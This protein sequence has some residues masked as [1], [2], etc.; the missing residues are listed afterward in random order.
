MARLAFFTEL[1][2]QAGSADDVTEFSYAV[3][4]SL[5]DQQHDVRVFS[6][7]RESDGLPPSHPRLQILRPFRRW[8]WLEIPRLL[9]ILLEFQPEI[10][11]FIQPRREAF[12]GFTNATT[13][14]PALAP[15]IGRPRVVVSLY[16]VRARELKRNRLLLAAADTV[17]VANKQQAD[18]LARHLADKPYAPSIEIVGLPATASVDEIEVL[19]GLEQLRTETILFIP[20][21]VDEHKDLAPLLNDLMRAIPSL[22]VIIGGGYGSMKSLERREFMSRLDGSRVLLTGPLTAAGE[23]ACLEASSLVLLAGLAP[24]SLSLARY[25]RA[26]LAAERPLVLSQ[27]QADLDPFRWRHRENSLI[28]GDLRA[29]L[30][31]ALTNESL[32]REIRSRLP[33]FARTEAVDEPGNAMSRIY[34]QVLRA[35]RKPLR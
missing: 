17:I 13:A 1:L 10:L 26:A 25:I 5:A 16:D 18:E 21:D 33:D 29:V 2:P 15:A 8:S 11:H 20:G 9:P 12:G 31:E 7:Y 27:E 22:G 3:M 30:A 23:R 28:A 14:L 32:R 24:S 34:A 35:P 19:P 4:T 6:T